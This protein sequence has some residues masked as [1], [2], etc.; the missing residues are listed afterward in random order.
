MVCN[1]NIIQTIAIRFKIHGF[2][3]KW[4]KVSISKARKVDVMG[5]NGCE[6]QNPHAQYDIFHLKYTQAEEKSLFLL[7]SVIYRIIMYMN[8]NY[9]SKK[10][11]Q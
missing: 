5:K 2:L 10:V 4:L 11:T 9:C 1:I 3:Q 7:T 8:N 6:F